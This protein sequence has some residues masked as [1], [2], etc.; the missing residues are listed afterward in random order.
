MPCAVLVLPLKDAQPSNFRPVS[1]QN[2]RTFVQYILSATKRILNSFS[3]T[4]HYQTATLKLHWCEMWNRVC[5]EI[6]YEE[7]YQT[8]HERR[9]ETNW[10]ALHWMTQESWKSVPTIRSSQCFS[11]GKTLG[12]LNGEPKA[13]TKPTSFVQLQGCVGF[14]SKLNVSE[15][16]ARVREWK[17][18]S[19]SF[20]YL[21]PKTIEKNC[22]ICNTL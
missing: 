12:D 10:P 21:S 14:A 19:S 16:T 17:L 6:S 8:M 22:Q 11:L 9:F 7:S 13:K 1:F 5:P 20:I 18:T 2:T 3:F 4:M 15:W